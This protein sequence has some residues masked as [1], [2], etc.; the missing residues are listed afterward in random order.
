MSAAFAGFP[1]AAGRWQRVRS[2]VRMGRMR[3]LL[4]GLVVYALGAALASRGRRFDVGAY[5]LGQLAVSATQLMTH[6]AND[7]FDLGADLVNETPT[8]WSGGSRV[9]PDGELAP[10]VARN[11]ALVMG[12]LALVFMAGIARSE[13]PSRGT[14]ALLAAAF[15]LSWQY[16]APP[17]RL[18]AHAL[19]PLTAAVV[20]AG[21]TPLVGY[22]MQGA[23]W[24]S[25]LLLALVPL[26]LAQ[27][28][29]ILVLDLPDMV[30]DTRAGKVTIAVRLGRRRSVFIV[31]GFAAA[32]YAVLPVLWWLGLSGAVVLSVSFTLPFAAALL[33]ALRQRHED[34]FPTRDYG[35]MTWRAV[36]WF[37]AVA[38][39][40]LAGALSL[41]SLVPGHAL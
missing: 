27:F 21:L 5:V 15:V 31:V 2:L 38:A 36:L 11:A 9:L 1:A 41:S 18:H 39:A 32:T 7:Y 22:G 8:T 37:S 25:A 28:A 16:S 3:F 29:M 4:G 35:R 12:A 14:F 13:A 10:V 20:V 40:E 6:Y 26:M 17:L 34:R 24:S 33:A 30:G 19:G 23:A